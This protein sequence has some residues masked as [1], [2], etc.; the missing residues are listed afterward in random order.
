MSLS[1]EITERFYD[2]KTGDLI[3][4]EDG[5]V[6]NVD[7]SI[8]SKQER[9][10]I[11]QERAQRLVTQ[12]ASKHVEEPLVQ[13]V[14]FPVANADQV[15]HADGGVLVPPEMTWDQPK[16]SYSGQATPSKNQHEEPLVAPEMKWD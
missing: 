9:L 15:S 8:L 4:I 3:E 12:E 5:V 1:T 14:M 16:P 2:E 11:N 6:V 13:P 10:T 7:K